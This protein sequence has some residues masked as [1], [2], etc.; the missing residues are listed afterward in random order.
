[1]SDAGGVHSASGGSTVEAPD[2][3]ASGINIERQFSQAQNMVLLQSGAVTLQHKPIER[4]IFES[5]GYGSALQFFKDKPDAALSLCLRVEEK[6]TFAYL[7]YNESLKHLE[8]AKER[9]LELEDD[10][11]TQRNDWAEHKRTLVAD[12]LRSKG[13]LTARGIFERYLQLIAVENKM[14]GKFN[15]TDVCKQLKIFTPIPGSWTAILIGGVQKTLPGQ[16]V[17]EYTAALYAV[18]SRD[19]HGHPWTGNAVE[20]IFD[21]AK[22]DEK[23]HLLVL[24]ILCKG[25]GLM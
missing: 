8:D 19:I 12:G 3:N 10:K 25:M 16:D 2:E 7:M 24:Q 20:L 21:D 14:K 5:H 4:E 9:I 15:A 11:M 13:L 17:S 22:Q 1:M 6:L 18:L 23:S